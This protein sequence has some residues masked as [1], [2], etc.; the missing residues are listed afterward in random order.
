MELLGNMGPVESHFG[1]F[2][3]LVLMQDRCMVCAKWMLILVV[4]DG[5]PR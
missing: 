4:V 2:G 3:E 1:P 5:T